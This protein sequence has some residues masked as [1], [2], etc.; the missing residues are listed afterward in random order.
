MKDLKEAKN[1]KKQSKT[2]LSF[3]R[4][5]EHSEYWKTGKK[6]EQPIK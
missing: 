4:V 1:V 2:Y 6:G 3:C 5:Q